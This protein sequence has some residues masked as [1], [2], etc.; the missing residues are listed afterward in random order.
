ML[1]SLI[2]KRAEA[3][4]ARVHDGLGRSSFAFGFLLAALAVFTGTSL[5]RAHFGNERIGIV[6]GN[7]SEIWV[8]R[9]QNPHS[10][11]GGAFGAGP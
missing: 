7:C 2:S 1:R 11:V 3:T 5:A 4:S 9:I 6:G 10:W 8:V